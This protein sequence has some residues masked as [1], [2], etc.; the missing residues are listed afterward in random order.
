MSRKTTLSVGYQILN[1]SVASPLTLRF[2]Q[3]TDTQADGTDTILST[4]QITNAADLTVASHTLTFTIGTQVL[5]PGVGKPEVGSDYYILAVADPTNTISESDSD[6]LNEDNTVAFAGAYATGTTIHLHGGSAADAVTLTYPSAISGTVSVGLSGSISATYTYVYN[7]TA[8]FRM[9][10]HGGNDTVSVVN[11][12]NLTARPMFEL[13][14]DGDD[15]LNGASGADTLNGGAGDDTLSGKLGNDS[16]DGG[17]GLNTLVETG[18][19]SFTLTNASVTGIG[20]DKLANL[21]VANLT[22]GI[23][24]NTFTVSGWTGAGSFVGGG[25]T[26]DAIVATKNSDFTLSNA[27]LQTGDG[28]NVALAGFSKA[29]LTGGV[30]NNTFTVS[31]WTG[32]GAL[33]GGLGTDQLVVT[34]DANMTLTNSSLVTA[35]FGTLMLSSI[36]T[37][38]LTGG[39]SANKLIANAFTL[40]SVTLQ[41]GD[42]DDVLVGGSQNDSLIGGSGRDLLIGGLGADTLGGEAGDDILIGGKCTLSGNVT[43]LNAIMAEWTSAK[44]YATRVANLSKG[45][46]ANGSTKLNSASVQNDS[47]AADQLNGN[48][49]T[50]WFF[51]SAGDILV[52]FNAGIGELKTAI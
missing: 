40:G 22:G 14:G 31:A 41:G 52:D 11:S 30:D 45:G 48:S 44:S 34:R 28:M 3:S 17:S 13:G 4:V 42:G 29:T 50:D 23:G 10:T 46:G 37:A 15:V 5:L 39:D 27:R 18:N 9:R 49:E 7:S 43:A 32:T 1:V 8:Q 6:P 21:Q 26:G 24:N 38:N 33:T 35:G 19:V 20:I 47:S 16:L 2:L 51:Q 25:G 12:S 36:E